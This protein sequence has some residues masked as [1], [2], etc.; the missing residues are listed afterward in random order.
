MASILRTLANCLAVVFIGVIALLSIAAYV[1]I[2][3]TANQVLITPSAP[4]LKISLIGPY[5]PTSFTQHELLLGNGSNALYTLDPNGSNGQLLISAMG[6]DPAWATLGLT[7]IT[8]VTGANSLALTATGGTVNNTVVP[9]ASCPYTVA[10]NDVVLL[11]SASNSAGCVV[12]LPACTGAT[13]NRLIYVKKED[14]NAQN[15]VVTPKMADSIE[16]ATAGTA[17]NIMTQYAVDRYDCY[18]AN[19]WAKL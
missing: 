4:G 3:G 6:A 9:F 18:V 17:D 13:I 12:N 14:A 2:I 1:P 5:L 8:A 15:I 10:A 16:G 11:A 19:H 7:G